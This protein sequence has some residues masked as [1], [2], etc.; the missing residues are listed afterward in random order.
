MF[1]SDS[2]DRKRH[3]FDKRLLQVDLVSNR[4]VF[5]LWLRTFWGCLKVRFWDLLKSCLVLLKSCL[6]L[7]SYCIDILK[8]CLC[9][10]KSYIGLLKSSLGLLKSCLDLL[11]YCLGFFRYC[12]GLFKTFLAFGSFA[13]T[14]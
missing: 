6:G 8:S 10:L 5:C 2:P 9:L 13:S 7:L 4:S 3:S 1:I 12:L 11:R 14:Q